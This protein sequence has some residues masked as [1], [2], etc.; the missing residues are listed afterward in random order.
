MSVGFL[1]IKSEPIQGAGWKYLEW[2]L[3][4]LSV[5]ACP[6]NPRAT[7]IQRSALASKRPSFPAASVAD[8]LQTLQRAAA[9]APT[10]AHAAAANRA[11]IQY[12]ARRAA[13]AIKPDARELRLERLEKLR[14]GL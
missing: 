1:P 10:S 12:Q 14:N 13:E 2:E 6:S 3:L 8:E 9:T 4:E 7:V 5:V 11:L